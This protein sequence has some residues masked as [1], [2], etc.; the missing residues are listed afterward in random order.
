VKAQYARILV[1][2]RLSDAGEG[3][4]E[5]MKASE[6]WASIACKLKRSSNNADARASIVLGVGSWIGRYATW[7]AGTEIDENDASKVLRAQAEQAVI[8]STRNLH[9]AT[10]SLKWKHNTRASLQTNASRMPVKE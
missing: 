1:D 10:I 6:E 8:L 4:H 7:Y 2:E 3:I 9:L 5:Q